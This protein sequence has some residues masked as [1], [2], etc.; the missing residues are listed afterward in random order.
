MTRS[1]EEILASLWRTPSGKTRYFVNTAHDP[2]LL[3]FMCL[4]CRQLELLLLGPVDCCSYLA[5]L[6][7]TLYLSGKPYFS[8]DSWKKARVVDDRLLFAA[9]RYII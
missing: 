3:L 4:Y 2:V 6:S 7:C 5:I 1:Q 8:T 9:P